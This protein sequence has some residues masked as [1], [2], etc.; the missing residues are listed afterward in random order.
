M[1]MTQDPEIAAMG[2]I[3]TALGQLEDNQARAR[4][5]RYANERFG[6]PVQEPRRTQ[7]APEVP[8]H[9]ENGQPRP[10]AAEPN[11][12]DFADLF[13]KANPATNVDKALVAGYWLQFGS[14]QASWTGQEANNLLKDLGHGLPHITHATTNAQNHKPALMR[15]LSKAGKS[16]QARKTYRLT[17]AGVVRVREKLGLSGTVPPALA[18]N[19][20]EQSA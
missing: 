3:T 19:G 4:V 13:D 18:D 10:E 12:R 2:T 5:L 16:Q 1:A 15:Q 8:G 20:E 14:K 11:F 17:N 6:V 7:Q 9:A